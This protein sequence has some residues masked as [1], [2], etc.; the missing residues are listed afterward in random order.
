MYAD[1]LQI[2]YGSAVDTETGAADAMDINI[3]VPTHILGF[4]L[5]QVEAEAA[6][7]TTQSVYSLDVST[8]GIT[9]ATRA[10]KATLTVP[11]STAVG[12]VLVSAPTGGGVFPIK[13]NPGDRVTLEHKTAANQA[14][15][16]H[17]QFVVMR[18]DGMPTESLGDVVAIAS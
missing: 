14:G 8:D 5:V 3:A 1:G 11:K 13:C 9:E 7:H 6:D 12:K 15:G 16:S 2:E 18:V 17:V 4:G 10:E